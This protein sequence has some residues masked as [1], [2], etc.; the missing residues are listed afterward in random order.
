MEKIGSRFVVFLSLLLFGLSAGA[1]GAMVVHWLTARELSAKIAAAQGTLAKALGQKVVRA[2]RF[3]VVAKDGK[4]RAVLDVDKDGRSPRLRL[5]DKDGNVRARLGL[6]KD[7]AP[8]LLL[9]GKGGEARAMLDLLGLRLADE[10]G[11]ERASLGAREFE[12]T[13]TG[14]TERTPES[15]LVLFDKEGK[16]LWQA[17][18]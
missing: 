8:G 4:V 3:E 9:W 7:G 11:K 18:P 16:V 13:R 17:P 1:G 14:A 2:Q 5:C 12:R 15:S 6:G 10:D